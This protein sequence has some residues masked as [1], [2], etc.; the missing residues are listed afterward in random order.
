MCACLT[1]VLIEYSFVFLGGGG[2]AL[3]DGYHCLDILLQIDPSSPGGDPADGLVLPPG[4]WHHWPTFGPPR[5][6]CC[7]PWWGH[8]YVRGGSS[9]LSAHHTSA[10]PTHVSEKESQH[11]SLRERGN[12][13][14]KSNYGTV[15]NTDKV[16]KVKPAQK[17]TSIQCVILNFG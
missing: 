14:T 9:V 11:Q 13:H 3:I 10:L 15:I 12:K 4:C 5:I 17:S 8:K 1:L 2:I 7:L 6:G 16:R